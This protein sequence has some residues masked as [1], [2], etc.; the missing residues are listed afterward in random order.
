MYAELPTGGTGQARTLGAN[1][2][3]NDFSRVMFEAI[4]WQTHNRG[5]SGQSRDAGTTFN[6]HLQVAF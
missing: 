1:W 3:L 5:G 6:T 4:R 2:Y